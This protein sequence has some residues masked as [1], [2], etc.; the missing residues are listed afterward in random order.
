MSIYSCPLA[1]F[2]PRSPCGERLVRAF[3]HYHGEQISIHAP[4]VGS[5]KSTRR[6]S[7]WPFYFNPRSPCG[8]RLCSKLLRKEPKEFQSTLPV[9][10]ATAARRSDGRRVPKISI[11]APRVGSDPLVDALCD[12]EDAFQSTLPV[13]GATCKRYRRRGDARFQSTLPVWGATLPWLRPD[14]LKS[15]Q[16][17]LP[18]WGATDQ[19]GG[20]GHQGIISIHAPR[21]G[22]DSR[23]LTTCLV[24]K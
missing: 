2:N 10:G 9:W 15:F 24:P 17:T 18:V 16:S 23:H 5:D 4:R 14:R 7:R 22:S 19:V 21:V 13:W 1:D 11:H 8:E 20:I 6:K 12:G 3:R